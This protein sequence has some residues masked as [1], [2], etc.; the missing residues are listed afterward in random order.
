[1]RFSHI[2]LAII[3]PGR[4]RPHRRSTG[5]EKEEMMET[6]ASHRPK[7]AVPFT[8]LAFAALLLSLPSIA[9]GQAGVPRFEPGE[10]PFAG[11]EWLAD[12]R[13]DCGY[14]IVPENRQK[15]DGRTLRLAVAILRSTSPHPEPDPVLFLQGGPGL[16][17]LRYAEDT[18]RNPL[19]EQIRVKR[20]YILFDQRGTGPEERNTCLEMGPAQLRV[21]AMDLTPE[22]H[23]AR[24]LDIVAD[25]RA[26][27]LDK[28]VDLEAYNTTQSAADLRD[29]MHLLPYPEWNLFGVSY[30]TR[31]ALVTMRDYPDRIRSV[32][33]DSTLPI[34]GEDFDQA[35]AHFARDLDLLFAA[36]EADPRCR[37]TYPG[38]EK[39]FYAAVSQF[40]KNPL[41]V[42]MADTRLYP[43]GTFVA[44]AQELVYAI[45]MSLSNTRMLPLMPLLIREIRAGNADMMAA[46]IEGLAGALT[47]DHFN[48]GTFNSVLCHD[49]S[50]FA[51]RANFKAVSARYPDAL[52]GMGYGLDVCEEWPAGRATQSEIQPVRSAIPTLILHG[53]YD[54]QTPPHFGEEVAGRLENGFLYV[55]PGV[56]H[57]VSS[58]DSCAQS[59]MARFVDAPQTRLDDA[60]LARRPALSFA[61][62]VYVNGGVFRLMSGAIA[63]QSAFHL[64]WIGLTLLVLLSAVLLWP[65]S[66]AIRRLRGNLDTVPQHQRIARW[67]AGVTAFLALAFSMGLGA[68][69]MQTASSNPMMLAFGTPGSAR[70]LFLIPPVLVPLSLGVL[71]ACIGA[72]R[73][74]YGGFLWR[75]HYS[76]V[77]L[78]CLGFV[79]FLAYWGFF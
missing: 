39:E 11:S 5:I 9:R 71:L 68:V 35:T 2:I 76:L 6:I 7:T 75:V 44:S 26:E 16:G 51:S 19:V 10:C 73:R 36:C 58:G 54:H 43:T 31:L 30:G 8:A 32:I 65:V 48:F 78:A 55:F 23:R 33:L 40:E 62:D 41:V 77:A 47:S 17:S 34:A 15:D 4:G 18:V 52:K 42:P 27:L 59:L 28:G 45:Y 25:C 63:R 20:D 69:V 74:S 21:F 79:V 61:T 70:P 53:E 57:Y 46:I 60:C 56:G 13:I 38:L 50:L 37:E 72:W 1:M 64:A 12:E 66:F 3:Y 49:E 29:L 67:L 24:I 22:Q 14:L